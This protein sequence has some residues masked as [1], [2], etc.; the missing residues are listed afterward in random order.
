MFDRIK[1][2]FLADNQPAVKRVTPEQMSRTIGIGYSDAG[3][4]LK[5]ALTQGLIN[6]ESLRTYYRQMEDNDETVGVGLEFLSNAAVKQIGSYTHPDVKIQDFV[7]LCRERLGGTL[8]D[9]RQTLLS[10]TLAHGYGV[11]EFTLFPENGQWLLSGLVNYDP[12]TIK[13]RIGLRADNSYGITDVEQT[14][15][16]EQLVIPREKAI[17]LTHG[18]TRTPYGRSRLRRA[19]RWWEFK[20]AV[21]QFWALGLERYSSPTAWA[22]TSGGEDA[23]EKLETAL[24]TIHSMGWIVTSIDDKVSFLERTGQ[25]AKDCM[26]AIEYANK[27]IYRC[28]FLPSLMGSGEQGGSYSLGQVHFEMFQTAVAW[29]ARVMAENELEQLWRPLIEW[30]FGPQE[31]YG[32]LLL[33]DNTTPEEKEI[34]SRVFQNCVNSGFVDPATDADWLRE[35]LGFPKI[36]ETAGGEPG[37]PGRLPPKSQTGKPDVTE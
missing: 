23:V 32:S 10:N 9:Y 34:M 28:L 4:Q 21:L 27:M 7:D 30:N 6:S 13:F 1:R 18:K 17:I 22:Q 12:M 19:Y 5:M 20:K 8:E 2:I 29:Q 36:D 37:W 31:S 15:S 24:S 11:S 26:E 16:G 33:V 14:V 3:S 35:Q 25:G